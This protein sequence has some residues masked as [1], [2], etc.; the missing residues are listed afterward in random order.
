MAEGDTRGIW[1][2]P[3]SGRNTPLLCS[4]HA[5]CSGLRPSEPG[6]SML[7]LN[8]VIREAQEQGCNQ[9]GVIIGASSGFSTLSLDAKALFH[10]GVKA[11]F[12]GSLGGGDLQVRFMMCSHTE[13]EKHRG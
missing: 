11:C 1:R 4:E 8:V 6:E 12:C 2:S 9:V 7:A 10:V 13:G 3:P 5:S